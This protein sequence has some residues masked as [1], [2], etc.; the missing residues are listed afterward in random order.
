M[1]IGTGGHDI[2]E[3]SAL[4]H[5]F[6]YA[7]GHDFTARDLQYKPTQWLPGKAPDQFAPPGPCLVTS[8]Q[9]ADPQSR[10]V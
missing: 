8:D 10:Q 6:G 4:S 3:A 7:I 5:V 1:I 9:I 2:P